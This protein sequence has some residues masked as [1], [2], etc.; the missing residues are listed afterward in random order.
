MKLA[1]KVSCL[2][3]TLGL[4]TSATHAVQSPRLNDFFQKN[5]LID[6]LNKWE[7][8]TPDQKQ[9]FF[10]KLVALKTALV[11]TVND[12]DKNDPFGATQNFDLL[13]DEQE[14]LEEAEARIGAQKANPYIQ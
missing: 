10:D 12:L 5:R 9:N 7:M 1:L 11:V 14:T 3:L 6:E 4:A 8:L 2:A 13:Q